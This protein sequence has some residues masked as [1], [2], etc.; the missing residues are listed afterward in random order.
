MAEQKLDYSGTVCIMQPPTKLR[1]KGDEDATQENIQRLTSLQFVR[2][3]FQQSF[4]PC[5]LCQ[6]L[7]GEA[8]KRM[9]NLID[10]SV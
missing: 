8:A 10:W 5:R 9:P 3:A 6:A 1:D 2:V 4:W 7:C